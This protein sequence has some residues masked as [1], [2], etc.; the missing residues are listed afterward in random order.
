MARRPRW[1]KGDSAYCEVQR[2]VDRQFFF[3]PDETIRQIIGSA[4]ARAQ[5]RYPVKLYWVDCNINH[6]QTGKAPLSDSPEHLENMV[7]FDQ[8]FNSLAARGINKY[9]GREGALFSTRNRS[10][11]A[12]DDLSLE[13]EVLDRGFWAGAVFTAELHLT[14]DSRRRRE[15]RLT[16]PHGQILD[17]AEAYLLHPLQQTPPFGRQ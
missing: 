3:K 1:F 6:K 15:H 13:Q 9:L 16:V 8:M 12:I 10:Q 2:T 4:A 11:E 14:D 7:R 5:K 17:A